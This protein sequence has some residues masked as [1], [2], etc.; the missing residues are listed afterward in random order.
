MDEEKKTYSVVGTVTIGSDEYRDLV[1]EVINA[2]AEYKDVD[3]RRS[4]LYW[5]CNDLE[6]KVKAAEEQMAVYKEFINS[7][8][9]IKAEFRKYRFESAEEEN[10]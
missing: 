9:L 4:E 2:R 8:E 6:K 1:E 7:S 10:D 3:R 5:K